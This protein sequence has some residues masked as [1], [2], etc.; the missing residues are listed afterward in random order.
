VVAALRAVTFSEDDNNTSDSDNDD[1]DSDTSA[2][3]LL[4]QPQP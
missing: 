3:R 1:D 2:E 4:A